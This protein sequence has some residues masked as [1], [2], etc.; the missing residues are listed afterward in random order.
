MDGERPIPNLDMARRRS[1]RKRPAPLPDAPTA[2]EVA[3]DLEPYRVVLAR[4]RFGWTRTEL[5]ERLGGRFTP[6][7]VAAVESGMVQMRAYEVE[8]L[9][10][11]TE[12]PVAYFKRGRP[13]AYLSPADV[14][15]C[16]SDRP[17]GRRP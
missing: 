1:R 16:G 12:N 4:Q 17:S 8:K 10:E 9:A 13:M 2:A 5:A 3:A 14:W 11:V 15:I 7:W 6:A